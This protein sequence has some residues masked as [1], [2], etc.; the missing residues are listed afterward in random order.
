MTDGEGLGVERD[1]RGE[2]AVQ[3]DLLLAEGEPARPR[4][5]VVGAGA[6]HRQRCGRA[7]SGCASSATPLERHGQ[8]SHPS[9]PGV[10]APHQRPAPSSRRSGNRRT[11]ASNASWPSMR[12]SAAPKQKWAA[13]P[14][15]RCRLSGASDVEAIRIG[16]ALGIAVG[17]RHHRHHRLPLPDDLAAQLSVGRAPAGR[18]A[19]WD[20]RSAASPRPRTGPARSRRAAG[21]APRDGAAG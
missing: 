6:R 21:R 18:C 16:K 1:V 9:E 10:V 3:P 19:G 4:R 20:S 14:K 17:G 2:L 8:G 11:M 15:A 5:S 13:Y 12:A 7:G